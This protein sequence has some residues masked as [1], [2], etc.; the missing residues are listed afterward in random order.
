MRSYEE[1]VA[2]ASLVTAAGITSRSAL[3]DMA[4]TEDRPGPFVAAGCHQ[5]EWGSQRTS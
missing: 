3:L 1:A 5:L 2:V 4:E